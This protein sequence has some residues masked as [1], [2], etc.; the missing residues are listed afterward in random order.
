MMSTMAASSYYHAPRHVP[1]PPPPPTGQYNHHHHHHHQYYYYPPQEAT[2]ASSSMA[3][4]TSERGGESCSVSSEEAWNAVY[5]V[6]GSEDERHGR[7]GGRSNLNNNNNHNMRMVDDDD[8]ASSSSMVDA[9][10]RTV[11]VDV[12]EF[13]PNHRH[14]HRQLSGG[15]GS[16]SGNGNGNH[17]VHDHHYYGNNY[18]IRNYKD[19]GLRFEQDDDGVE[20]Y[21]SQGKTLPTFTSTTTISSTTGQKQ[22]PQP[23]HQQKH[24]RDTSLNSI[25][26]LTAEEPYLKRQ[27]TTM[28]DDDAV[29]EL[30]KVQSSSAPGKKPRPEPKAKAVAPAV[31]TKKTPTIPTAVIPPLT[32]S[33]GAE[34]EMAGGG[35]TTTTTASSSTCSDVSFYSFQSNQWQARFDEL[36]A[37]KNVH[38]HCCIP[39]KCQI[40]Y[41]LA[42]WVKRQRYQYRLKQ[43]AGKKSTMTTDR[44]KA[45]DD[46]GFIWDLHDAV[47]E[48]RLNELYAFRTLHGH[49]KVPLKYPANPELAIW[50]KCQR[51]HYMTYCAAKNSHNLAEKEWTSG[52]MTLE[53][54]Q[55]LTQVGFVF[56]NR[57]KTSNSTEQQERRQRPPLLR[58]QR[59]AS[60]SSGSSCSSCIDEIN[61]PD[62][63]EPIRITS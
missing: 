34:D 49:C 26:F 21:D 6:L 7:D 30:P 43:Q 25:E 62:D 1:P 17:T 12:I 31:P 2:N 41:P 10:R 23:Y 55:K 8:D 39:T 4:R 44:Q 19:A 56:A 22:Y 52:T 37:Y 54:I 24:Y 36:V 45:L 47:W 33:A 15:S 11:P 48:E 60:C 16:S 28:M 63:W 38:G 32:T 5:K 20:Y 3:A 13:E 58:R 29:K 14:H 42:Q 18:G 61:D 27:K 46:L 40:N 50:A 59:Q 35:T 9:E 57:N 53:R 51:R